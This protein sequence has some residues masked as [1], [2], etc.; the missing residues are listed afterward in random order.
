MAT[1]KSVGRGPWG[2]LLETDK[3]PIINHIV[4]NRPRQAR[5]RPFEVPE[6]RLTG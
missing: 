6:S 5:F 4:I 2:V 3:A 1:S